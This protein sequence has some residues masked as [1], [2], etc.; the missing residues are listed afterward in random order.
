MTEPS[1]FDHEELPGLLN[2]IE[3]ILQHGGK[4]KI[5]DVLERLTTYNDLNDVQQTI[6]EN[7]KDALT[8]L[9]LVPPDEYLTDVVRESFV[10]YGA[11][12]HVY[13]GRWK[14]Q[15]VV[16]VVETFRPVT[17]PNLIE[18]HF[19]P[20]ASLSLKLAQWKMVS[21]C[22][23]VW[24][25]SG[26][27]MWLDQYKMTV[28]FA[29]VSPLAEGDLK[30]SYMDRQSLKPKKLANYFHD[31]DRGL[32]SLHDHGVIHGNI[33]CENILQNEGRCYLAGFDISEFVD[34][35]SLL[36]PFTPGVAKAK[37]GPELIDGSVTR[38]D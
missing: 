31:V 10:G 2:E 28:V 18:G 5:D 14:E 23:Y 3:D 24:P 15:Q 30:L 32:Q 6:V 1:K 12:G 11:F 26:F 13:E 38:F 25:V 20:F 37:R 22:D 27:T 29:L 16:T 17:P 9:G 34:N 36:F 7:F 19:K 35:S 4:H 8:F 33:H 21:T